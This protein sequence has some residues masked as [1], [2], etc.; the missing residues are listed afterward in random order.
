M[1]DFPLVER[2]HALVVLADR[3]MRLRQGEGGCVLLHGEAGVGK[4]SLLRELRRRTEAQASWWWGAC[5]PLLSAPP[6][7]P[8]IDMVDELPVSLA[9]AVRGS[10]PIQGVLS[11]ML[12]LLRD[13]AR[14]AVMV[15]EDVHWA[16]GA[17]LDLIRFIGRRLDATCSLLVLTHRDEGLDPDHPLRAV[18]GRLPA[19]STLRMRLL[20]LSSEGVDELARRA[21]RDARHLHR[22]TQ[23]NPFYVTELL[24]TPGAGLPA[25]VRD[26]VLAR[27]AGVSAQARAMLEQVS[28]ATVPLERALATEAGSPQAIAEC[29]GAGLLVEQH[30]QLSFRHEIAR[31]SVEDAIAAPRAKALHAGMFALLAGR[32]GMASRQVH[33][34][35]RAGLLGEVFSLACVAARE[36]AQASAHRQAAGLYGLAL[37]HAGPLEASAQAGLLEAQ[38]NESMFVNA[39]GEAMASR[40]QALALRQRMGDVRGAGINL[41]WMAR[42]EYFRTGPAAALPHAQA[43]VR[44]LEKQS[45]RRELAMAYATMAQVHVLDELAVDSLRWGRRALRLAEG[46][47]D[48]EVTSYALNTV[49]TA[50]LRTQDKPAHWR[51][52]RR[53]LALALESGQEEHAARAYTNLPS[54]M[55]VHRRHDEALQV[56]AEGI[57]FCESRDLD[58]YVARLRIRRAYALLEL[59]RWSEVPAELQAVRQLPELTPVEAEQALHVEMIRALRRG[60]GGAAVQAYWRDHIDGV[61]ALGLAPWYLPPAV[62]RVE[63]AWLRGDDEAVACIALDALPMAERAAEPWRMGQLACWLRRVGRLPASMPPRFLQQ[64]CEPA[65]LELA[66]HWQAASQAWARRGCV[67]EQALALLGGDGNAQQ[68]ALA[69]LDTLGAA[70]AAS[71][72]RR[73]L[74]ALGLRH[75]R[76]GPKNRTRDDPLGLTPRERQVLHL[77]G[78]GSSNREIAARLHRSERTVEH[79]VS[80]LLAKLGV[81]SRGEAV[82][83]SAALQPEAAGRMR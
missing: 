30:G 9:E 33:H 15:F 13:R 38:A 59:G 48:A 61:R 2:D 23:G 73:R 69:L 1:D 68:Q 4:T 83:R 46:L 47:G 51:Q 76:V 67:Y 40:Q 74:R 50:S 28:V 42:L 80:A 17:T 14:P 20:P 43:A 79:H 70:P 34:A 27:V 56:C 63:A 78:E 36:A 54:L 32:P 8:L 12:A 35:Q 57:A 7:G 45:D 49:G 29:L 53:S 11:G 52:L 64:V 62:V 65:R 58:M 24:A 82:S 60:D 66:G 3:V 81:A 5:E 25:S 71:I 72:A 18:L 19:P 10:A 37:E 22:I 75:A 55:L 21:G 6:L 16:D 31:Q 41:R 77:L 44:L 26:A 39:I